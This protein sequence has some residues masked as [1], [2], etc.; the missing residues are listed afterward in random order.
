MKLIL[1][2]LRTSKRLALLTVLFGMLSGAASASLVALINN[3]LTRS[4]DISL[5][6]FALPFMGMALLAL[7]TRM[8]SQ[9]LLSQLQQ[10]IL[11]D[12]R[13]RLSRH[14][15]TTSLRN[16]EE[17]GSHRMLNSIIQDTVTLGQ[18]V[19]Q[20]PEVFINIAI[21][22]GGLI[23]LA[24]LSWPLFL[25][26]LAFVVLGQLTYSIPSSIGMR[27]QRQGREETHNLFRRFSSMIEGSKELRLNNDRR[28]AFFDSELKPIAALVRRLVL[29]SDRYFAAAG[30]WGMFIYTFAIGVVLLVVPRMGNIPAAELVGAVL[31]VLYL[32]QPLNSVTYM[33]PNLRRA[34]VALMQI[35]KLGMTLAPE[36]G[37][38]ELPAQTQPRS[39]ELL[40][41]AGITHTY[42]NERD[43]E[44]FTL[45]PISLA[46]R[47]GEL[48]FLVGGNGSG[49]TTLAKLLTG[50]YSPEAGEVRLNGKSV[51]PEDLDTLRQHFSAVFFDFHVF[52]R[53]LGLSSPDLVKQASAYLKEL[54]L[55]Q[56]VTIAED[57]TLSTTKLSQGQ[58]KRLALL[59]AY[60][61]DRPIYVFDEWAADQD[62]IFKEIFY[63]QILV[64]LKKRGKALIVISH[65]DRYFKLADRI[66]RLEFGQLLS[67]ERVGEPSTNVLSA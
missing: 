4:P 40:E 41:L 35:E 16:L 30:S 65:D 9:F 57:G 22:T 3:V 13:L 17:S 49:K 43:D 66:I 24:W 34:E 63:R 50:L 12:M 33:L 61:E 58:R 6:S 5:T 2:L 27:Y 19:S 53:L 11:M 42:R 46:L 52:D 28:R 59:V 15:L 38:V 67:D 32:Q 45:G 23:Y 37:R 54:H 20:L 18:G 8:A 55:D 48:V 7:L 36:N 10:E 26:I 25:V 64:D 21:A 56:K 44:K 31:V 51:R 62:P 39:F 14:L 60:L 1:I 47:P 29:R